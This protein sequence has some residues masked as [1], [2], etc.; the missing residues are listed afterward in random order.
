MPR[1]SNLKIEEMLTGAERSVLKKGI[2]LAEIA[3]H[4]RDQRII[5]VINNFDLIL[6]KRI[7]TE[8][9]SARDIPFVI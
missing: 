8:G 4:K 3:T 7:Y 1:I 5:I 9:I 6:F 2:H